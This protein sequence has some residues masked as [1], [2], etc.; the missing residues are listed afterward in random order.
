D[1]GPGV[2]VPVGV[3]VA[4]VVLP[5][6]RLGRDALHH[7]VEVG[8]AAGL[9][10][11]DGDAAGAVGHEDRDGPLG[12]A[13]VGDRLLREIGDVDDLTV[14]AGVEREGL[15]VNRHPGRAY[16]SRGVGH[17]STGPGC[18]TAA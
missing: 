5:A 11:D 15:V 12:H 10:L 18:K 4:L 17:R 2:A 13:A 8:V 7:G 6:V 9:A 3:G 14:A 16:W 1:P